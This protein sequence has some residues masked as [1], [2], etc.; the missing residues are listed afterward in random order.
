MVS[1]VGRSQDPV[2]IFER[3]EKIKKI[4]I[5]SLICIVAAAFILGVI[6]Y[7][8]IN[9]QYNGYSVESKIKVKNGN[10][11]QYRP[12]QGGVVKYSRDGVSAVDVEGKELWNGSY[13]ME[14]PAIDISGKYVCVADIGA[15]NL[16]VYNGK[17]SGTEITTDNTILQ[18]CVSSQGVV[19]VIL[20]ESTS[21]VIQVYNPYDPS[22]QLLVEIP[23]NVEDGYPVS[24]DISPDGTAL[25]AA[26][27]CVTSGVVESRVTFYNFTDVGKNTNCLVGSK[28]YSDRLVSEV[29]FMDTEHACLFSEKGISIWEDMKKP[30]Q[31]TSKQYKANI[32]NAF[33][34]EN[35]VGVVLGSDERGKGFLQVY[36]KEGKRVLK[37]KISTE[38]SQVLLQDDEILMNSASHCYIY[39]LNGVK[40]LDCDVKERIR[41]L[42]QAPGRN[43]YILTM[44]SEIKVISLDDK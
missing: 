30:K 12:Y 44:D 39:K 15:K 31:V 11:L 6:F 33:L 42:Y 4:I 9:R 1:L 34:D 18:S 2:A 7:F 8:Y 43:E 40:R 32:R 10:L 41:E 36:D 27:V 13:D 26:Y 38:F 3:R 24:I 19:A 35:Y 14:K 23:T 17:D 22:R 37:L 25:I 29:Q 5:V 28:K 20:E 21:N 16:C